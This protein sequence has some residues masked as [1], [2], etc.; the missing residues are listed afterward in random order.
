MQ[1]ETAYGEQWGEGY[2]S[3]SKATKLRVCVGGAHTEGSEDTVSRVMENRKLPVVKV[4]MKVKPRTHYK[5]L[6]TIV[7]SQHGKFE[8]KSNL[9]QFF[10]SNLFTI[11]RNELS[12]LLLTLAHNAN[13]Q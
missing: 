8:Q 7:D 5:I 12:T 9:F 4:K 6:P 2:K 3:S 10:Q 1:V 11:S 13:S